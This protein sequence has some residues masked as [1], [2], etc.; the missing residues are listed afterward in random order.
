MTD[1]ERR[2]MGGEHD[3]CPKCGYLMSCLLVTCERCKHTFTHAAPEPAGVRELADSIER[4]ALK[5]GDSCLSA[6]CMVAKLRALAA[7]ATP[8]KEGCEGC[9]TERFEWPAICD[10]CDRKK[11]PDH[12]KPKATPTEEGNR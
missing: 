4:L 5:E 2:T 6:R 3:K 7:P 1:G 8:T 10:T 11:R 12:H 9:D